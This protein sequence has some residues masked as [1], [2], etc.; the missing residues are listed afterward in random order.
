MHREFWQTF[1]VFSRR[2]VLYN[3]IKKQYNETSTCGGALFN[4]QKN[5]ATGALG[6]RGG[7]PCM[8]SGSKNEWIPLR[9]AAF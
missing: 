7:A 2:G 9:F 3:P 5:G 6:L 4:E 1:A 8:S